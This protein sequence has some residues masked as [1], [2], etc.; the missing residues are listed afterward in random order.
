M[1]AVWI[2]WWA[3]VWQQR[4]YL[5]FPNTLGRCSRTNGR[6]NAKTSR[7]IQQGTQG[8][9]SWKIQRPCAWEDNVVSHFSPPSQTNLILSRSPSAREARGSGERLRHSTTWTTTAYA[10][11]S[12][13]RDE[14][15]LF[16]DM[17]WSLSWGKTGTRWKKNTAHCLPFSASFRFPFRTPYT[18]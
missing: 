10:C 3:G 9:R 5:I 4:G 12:S 14:P 15:T 8:Y 6:T 1:A 16:C 7:K 18:L 11:T 13:R 17:F 2:R